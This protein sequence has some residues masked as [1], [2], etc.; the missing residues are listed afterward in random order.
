MIQFPFPKPVT[1]YKILFMWN[2]TKSIL[3]VELYQPLTH[4]QHENSIWVHGS[5]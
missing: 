2:D 3:E 1:F 4:T 5:I